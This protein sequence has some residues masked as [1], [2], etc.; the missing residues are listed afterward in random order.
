[1]GP[2]TSHLTLKLIA[3]VFTGAC[4]S[5]ETKAQIPSQNLFRRSQ[6]IEYYRL[7]N[8]AKINSL[9]NSYNT[10]G[11][12]NRQY[13]LMSSPGTS[14]AVGEPVE[15]A[16]KC[17]TAPLIYKDWLQGEMFFAFSRWPDAGLVY[18]SLIRS[19]S[20]FCDAY[21]RLAQ[22]YVAQNNLAAAYNILIIAKR[23]FPDNPQLN[24]GLGQLYTL[25]S[26]PKTALYYFQK[27]TILYPKDPDGFLGTSWILT[28]LGRDKDALFYLD[29]GRKLLITDLENAGIASSVSVS[30]DYLYIFESMLYNRL[31]ENEKSLKTLDHLKSVGNNDDIVGYSKYLRG[32]YYYNKGEQFYGRAVRNLKKAADAGIWID[33]EIVRQLG[34]RFDPTDFRA[35]ALLQQYNDELR[36][37]SLATATPK[38][39]SVFQNHL[40][41]EAADLYINHLTTDSINCHVILR[42]AECYRGLEKHREAF[43]PLQVGGE[44]L[45]PGDQ[46]AI[47]ART[48]IVAGG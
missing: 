37:E 7:R 20:A 18:S 36:I 32:M 19:D 9:L 45:S 17:Q 35:I 47:A 3:L 40:L 24:V 48:A 10:P 13:P 22:T 6:F 23:K 26:Y 43:V 30:T 34:M 15:F 25:L 28:E 33:E 44:I 4:M 11:N 5:I 21:F 16:I 42:L 1:M 31:H 41:A 46:A 29:I 14:G 39:D 2:F 8:Q 27:Q 12:T 38:A